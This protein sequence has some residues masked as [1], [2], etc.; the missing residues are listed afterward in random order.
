MTHDLICSDLVSGKK[1]YF[2]LTLSV[3]RDRCLSTWPRMLAN[4]K[5]WTENDLLY[6]LALIGHGQS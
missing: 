2:K 1:A 6:K 3:S 4:I 5:L